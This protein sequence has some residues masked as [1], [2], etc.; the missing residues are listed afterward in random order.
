MGYLSHTRPMWEVE[1]LE[2][3][4][5]LQAPPLGLVPLELPRQLVSV[6]WLLH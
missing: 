2:L 3:E 4:V 1:P 6:E 5:L